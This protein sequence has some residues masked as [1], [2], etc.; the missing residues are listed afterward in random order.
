M[1][2][3]ETRQP[4]TAP[5]LPPPGEV[6][7]LGL[8]HLKRIWART[9]A[10]QRGHPVPA[11][12]DERHLDYLVIHAIGVG[13]EQTSDYFARGAPGF[14]DFERWIAATTGGVDPLRVARINAA[15]AG[16]AY[17]EE[18]KRWLAAVEASA[19]ALSA[20]DLAFWDAQGYVVLHDAVPAA[21][22]EAAAR[23]LWEHIDARPDDRESW[24]RRR[25]HGIM[26]QYFQHDAF[27]ANRR[28]A[29][30]HKAFAQIWGTADLWATT[31]RV[32]F[33]VPERP[34]WKFPAP[35][36]TGTSA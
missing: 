22:R 32:G 14:D 17:P 27:E 36:C 15:V 30:L 21:S 25:D 31:D 11:S 28:S 10:A 5:A 9:L 33:N 8:R 19:P 13:L 7:L 1:T 35:T 6:G 34:G 16:A 24:Y 3:V 18:I 23:A 20:D 4:P 26:V 29:R 12:L 2:L